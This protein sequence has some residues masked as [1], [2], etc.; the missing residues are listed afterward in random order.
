MHVQKVS[1]Q[2]R[3]CGIFPGPVDAHG[4]TSRQVSSRQ[5]TRWGIITDKMHHSCGGEVIFSSRYVPLTYL[6]YTYIHTSCRSRTAYSYIH[7]YDMSDRTSAIIHTYVL[8]LVLPFPHFTERFK[9]NHSRICIRSTHVGP[10]P[11]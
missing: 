4:V 2:E 8:G 10:L 9:R 11:L 6:V 1:R 5:D 3:K 7:T